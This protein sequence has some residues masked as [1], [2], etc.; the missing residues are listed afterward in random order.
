MLDSEVQPV[1]KALWKNGLN[2]VAIHNHMTGSGPTIYFLHYWGQGPA[3]NL[4]ASA[5]D[6]GHQGNCVSFDAILD[7]YNLHDP[8]LRLLADIVRAAECR[9]RIGV[10]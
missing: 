7:R 3:A 8:A 2:V 9:R 4:V 1:L 5:C 6:L 10:D